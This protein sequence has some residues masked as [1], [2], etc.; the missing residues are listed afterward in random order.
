MANYGLVRLER[1]TR[2]RIS[3]KVIHDRIELEL[4]LARKDRAA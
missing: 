4:P 2:G 3:A 1:G